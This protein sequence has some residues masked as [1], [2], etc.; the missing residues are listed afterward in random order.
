MKPDQHSQVAQPSQFSSSSADSGVF[1][2]EGSDL[3]AMDSAKN[4][5]NWILEEFAPFLKG[6]VADV[7]AGSGNFSTYLLRAKIDRLHAFEPSASMHRVLKDRFRDEKRFESVNSYLEEAVDRYASS[8][9]AVVYNNVME[10]VQDDLAELQAV[11][12][13]LKPGGY[14]L[15]YVPA[16]TWLYSEFDRSLGHFRRY[17]KR[18]GRTVLENAGFSVKVAKY[19]DILG[20]LPW[21]LFMKLMKCK[22]SKG[23]VGLYDRVGIPLTR[24]LESIVEPPVGKNILLVGRKH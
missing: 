22:L 6:S 8:F 24:F 21:L 19:A 5:P 23:N 14:V 10:H 3:E 16:M 15:I 7:G 12:K 20:I 2:Y 18:S 11:H 1:E 13:V 4:Y 9:D 17:D